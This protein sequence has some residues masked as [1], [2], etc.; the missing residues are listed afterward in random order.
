MC[1]PV[2]V[3][4]LVLV[5]PRDGINVE[6]ACTVPSLFPFPFCF[7]LLLSIRFVLRMEEGNSPQLHI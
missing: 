7:T 2:V 1:A 3:T 6:V 4:R 5:F